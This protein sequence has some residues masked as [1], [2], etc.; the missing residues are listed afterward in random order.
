MQQ[1][2][3]LASHLLILEFL[4]AAIVSILSNTQENSYILDL[5]FLDALYFM[6][7]TS[8]SVGYGDIYSH[9]FT[10]RCLVVTIVCCVFLVF[11]DNFS[12]MFQLMKQA[13]FEDKYYKLQNHIV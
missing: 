1:T 9:A 3:L 8:A 13:N 5:E 6:I 12:K 10:A 2:V 11:A 4:G 7:I